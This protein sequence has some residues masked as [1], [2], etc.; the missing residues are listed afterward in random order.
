[1]SRLP[2]MS[3]GP[4]PKTG[5]HGCL[6]LCLGY[7]VV[8]VRW[9]MNAKLTGSGLAGGAWISLW[10]LFRSSGMCVSAVISKGGRQSRVKG[11]ECAGT[12]T[13]ARL[14]RSNLAV[15]SDWALETCSLMLAGIAEASEGHRKWYETINRN[16][17]C[18]E[19]VRDYI[20]SF[21]ITVA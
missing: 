10:L 13:G 17:Q 11:A 15:G 4:H 8:P 21:P 2:P 14:L 5:F 19:V 20:I 6:C 3:S 1:M 12:S 7:Q 18:V 16:L 9:V